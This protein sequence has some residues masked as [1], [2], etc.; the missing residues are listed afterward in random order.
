MATSAQLREQI[1]AG[2]WDHRLSLLYGT[3]PAVLARQRARYGAALV[4]FEL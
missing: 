1:L 4:Q 2:A 3:D